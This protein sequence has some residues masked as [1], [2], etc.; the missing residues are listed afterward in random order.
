MKENKEDYSLSEII[1]E[2]KSFLNYLISKWL[3]LVFAIIIGLGLGFLYYSI[4]R[5]K[6]KA[7]TSFILEEKSAGGSGLAGLASQFGFN[8]GAL[9]GGESIFAGDNILNILQSKKVVEK[10]LLTKVD[11]VNKKT[12][13]DFY[14]EF[15][16]LRNRWQKKPFLAN[17]NFDAT[18][19]N[20]SPL[21]DSVLNVVY[22]NIVKKNLSAEKLSKQGTIYKVQVTSENGLFARLITERLVAEASR[23]YLDIRVGTAQRNISQLQRRSDS[24]LLLL[25]N[26][27]FTAAAS[28]PLDI[29]PG[30]RTAVVPVEIATRDKTVLATLYAEVTKNLEASKLLLSQQTPVIQL[31]DQ[32]EFLLDDNKKGLVFLL[33]V[34]IFVTS[35]LWGSGIFIYFFFLRGSRLISQITIQEKHLKS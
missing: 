33:V 26:K 27:S 25:N 24:L 18:A 6:Y 15:T 5:P 21:Q 19:K 16:G 13:A 4:Q 34:F 1:V 2:F 22:T 8:I 32:P 9:N 11:S 17:I 35:F 10:V 31:L 28:Q 20:L 23:L 29:N 30:I 3:H 12:L 14:L 7:T